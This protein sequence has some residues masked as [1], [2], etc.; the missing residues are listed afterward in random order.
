ML[1]AGIGRAHNIHLSTLANFRKPGDT[2]SS[3]RYFI[4]DIVNEP[5]TAEGGV[6]PVPHGAGIGVTLDWAFLETV[7]ASTETF[8]R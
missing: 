3:S 5:L 1:E 8:K 6:M 7:T 4:K 2:S